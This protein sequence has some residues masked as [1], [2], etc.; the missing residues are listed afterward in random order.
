[1]ASPIERFVSWA[2]RRR[3]LVVAGVAALVAVSS[4]G[5]P[6]LTFDA[7]VIRLLP[8]DGPAVRAFRT[9]LEHFGTFDDLYVV[10]SAGDGDDI[11]DHE[12]EVARW[13]AALATAP[14]IR[15]VDSGRL[16]ATRNW[17]WLADRQLLL[18]DEVTLPEGLARLQPDGMRSALA[19]SRELLSLPSADIAALVRA[20]PLGLN[21]LLR[22]Q[23]G[24]SQSILPMAVSLDG[25][26]TA[27][28]RRRLIVARPTRPPYDTTFSRALFARLEAIRAEAPSP[29]GVDAAPPIE[30]AFAGGHRIALEAEATVKRESIVNGIG[31]LALILPLLYIVFRSPWLV[32][33]G[34]VPSSVSLIVV[35]GLL[36]MTG[37]T[38]SAAATGASAML[39][40]LGVDG[41][42]LLY[43]THRQAVADGA[44]P[45]EAIRRLGGASASM[46][47]G[48]WTTAATFL[49]LLVVDFPS[50]EQ[51]GL[52]IGLSMIVCG[53]LTL[54]LVPASLSATPAAAIRPLRM[55]ALAAFVRRRRVAILVVAAVATGASAYFASALRVNPTLERLRSVTEGAVFVQQVSRE[56]GLPED[57]AVVLAEGDDLERLLEQNEALHQRLAREAP[58]L[59]V[60]APSALL[61]SQRTQAARARAVSAAVHEAGT[62]GRTLEDMAVAAGFRPGTFDGFIERLPRLLDANQRLAIEGYRSNGLG[63]LVDR[64]IGST[65]GRWRLATYAFPTSIGEQATLQSAVATGGEGLV[66]TGLAAVNAEMSAS[67]LP[68]FLRG[69]GVGSVLVIVLILITFRSWRLG[70]LTLVPTIIGLVWAAGLLGVARVELDLFAVF[71]VVTFVG[72]GVD[73]GVHLVHRYHD[74]G[75]AAAAT[76]ELAP[77]ILVAG[78]ITLLGYGTLIGSSYPPLRSIGIVSAV[79]VVTLV[80]ASVLVLPALLDRNRA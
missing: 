38:L 79:S 68:Q 23:M 44:A 7:D 14:E 52:L 37:A 65:N 45:G 78:A 18:F 6:R 20:D 10:F 74:R 2:H 58:A 33:I 42:V 16:D 30:V 63:D 25:Y 29:D 26:V 9:Y 57:V 3:A 5:L 24:G 48:M 43:V 35:L 67:F 70:W 76:A 60:H 21:E 27:D 64:F 40:G 75:D 4:A 54:A 36:G 15:R 51:L 56:F 28:A 80:A 61:P 31:A 34:A 50:L 39:F 32:V 47:L 12:D 1:L 8:H 49:G 71:A 66:L 77:V 41:V 19:A 17:S 62:L 53:L 73:Y 22:Q 69:L 59:T 11:R 55:P 72:I 46:L 13:V